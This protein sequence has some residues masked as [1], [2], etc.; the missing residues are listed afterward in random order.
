MAHFAQLDENNVV[1]NVIVVSNAELGE[2]EFPESETIGIAFCKSLFGLNTNWKQTSYN[3]NFRSKYAVIGG[4]YDPTQDVFSDPSL[5]QDE[6]INELKERFGAIFLSQP[7][8]SNSE[9]P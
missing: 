2:L 3:A 9:L 1:I 7:S 4:T 6:A 5:P 8:L